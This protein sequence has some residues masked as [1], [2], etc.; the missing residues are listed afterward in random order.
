[1][2]LP[3]YLDKLTMIINKYM[4]YMIKKLIKRILFYNK[5]LKINVRIKFKIL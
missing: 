4:N 5:K 3:N 2:L 1:M